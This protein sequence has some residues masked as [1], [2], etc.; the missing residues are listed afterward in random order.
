[1]IHTDGR[2]TIAH[3]AADSILAGSG[4]VVHPAATADCDGY[5]G[6]AGLVWV[7][8]TP[9]GEC[10]GDPGDCGQCGL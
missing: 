6:L 2:P 7:D 8:D 1:M 5:P 4:T 10:C 9:S 3:R